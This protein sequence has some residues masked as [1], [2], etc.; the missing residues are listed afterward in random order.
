ME[1]RFRILPPLVAKL[2]GLFPLCLVISGNYLFDFSAGAPLLSV[3]SAKLLC[4]RVFEQTQ[5]IRVEQVRSDELLLNILP[6]TV[7]REL[8]ETGKHTACLLRRGQHPL[9]RLQRFHQYCG[10]NSWQRARPGAG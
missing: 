10:I 4:T 7:A 1:Y 5:E 6:A 8:K 3:A 2:V 9:R